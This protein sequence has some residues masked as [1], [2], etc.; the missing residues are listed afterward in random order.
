MNRN[1]RNRD[2]SENPRRTMSPPRNCHAPASIAQMAQPPPEHGLRG[3]RY[4]RPVNILVVCTGN[5]CRSPMAEIVLRETAQREGLDLRVSSAGTSDEEHGHGLD[6][7]AAKVLREAGYNLPAS[8]FAHR[9]TT[10]E[11]READL[12]LAMTTG[13]A[14]ILQRM[15][16][17]SGVSTDKLHLWREFDGTVPFGSISDYLQSSPGY[18]DQYS[19]AGHAD[20]PDPWY[21][22]QDGFYRTLAVVESG[23]QGLLRWHKAGGAEAR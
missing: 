23:V 21:G 7:R 17:S 9:A 13:H 2:R 15:M 4:N 12:V 14:R 1:I 8:H 6:R 11:L 20:V 18:S 3:F 19:S 10:A 22:N 5:I 16:A